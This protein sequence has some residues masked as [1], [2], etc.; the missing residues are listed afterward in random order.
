MDIWVLDRNFNKVDVIDGYNSLIWTTRYNTYGDFELYI[1]ADRHI[2]NL[3]KNNSYLV[4]DKDING[5]EYKNVMIIDK[6]NIHIQTDIEN[7]DFLTVTG[8]C[9][10]SIVYR[11]VLI[12]QTVMNGNLIDCVKRLLNENIINPNDTK[13][14]INNF[15]FGTTPAI[16]TTLTMQAT[17]DNLGEL[18]AEICNNY[19]LGWDVYVKNKKFVFTIYKGVNRSADQS[20]NPHV[21]F[22]Y[23]FDNLLTTDYSESVGEYSNVAIIAGEGEGA[24]RKKIETGDNS[25]T[26]LNRIELFVD[27]R[28]VSSNEGEISDSEYNNMLIEKGAESLA[29]RQKVVTFEGEVDATRNYL[30]NRDFFMGDIVQ[31]MNEYGI[32]KASRITEIIDSD[33][34]TGNTIIPTFTDF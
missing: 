3:I 13:R 15:T 4:R 27:A 31:V 20:V 29:E 10:K 26:G 34:E 2:L 30:L 6:V 32:S 33:D 17:G 9:L 5:N 21:I 1:G 8:K 28:D 7:G 12:N 16:T 24:A 23:E 22:S 14:K 25:A 19:G 11:R 18:I